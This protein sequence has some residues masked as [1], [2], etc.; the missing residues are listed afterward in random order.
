MEISRRNRD[1]M[2]IAGAA[3]YVLNIV[4][5]A[6]DAHLFYFDVSDDLAIQWQPVLFT[7]KD[8]QAGLVF[9]VRF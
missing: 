2:T 8:F 5:A 1:L 3:V 9:S 4:D 6:V 7:Y